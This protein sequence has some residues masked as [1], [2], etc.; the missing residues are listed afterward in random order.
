MS[1]IRSTFDRLILSAGLVPVR[2]HCLHI[3]FIPISPPLSVL[4]LYLL[5]S[6]WYYLLKANVIIIM[7]YP[8]VE[9]RNYNYLIGMCNYF[10]ILLAA[11]NY[12]YF[13]VIFS[14]LE[15]ISS[16][17][18]CWITANGIGDLS[19]LQLSGAH[20]INLTA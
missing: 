19:G 9:M 8:L 12:T 6:A 2:P 17:N 5:K 14:R 4:F 3:V 16:F 20:G 18:L 7:Y 15:F 11:L 13:C 10:H 1:L